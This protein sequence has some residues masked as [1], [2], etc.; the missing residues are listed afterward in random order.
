M[1]WKKIGVASRGLV[2]S[3]PSASFPEKLNPRTGPAGGISFFSVPLVHIISRENMQLHSYSDF[4]ARKNFQVDLV[5]VREFLFPVLSP[6]PLLPGW[7]R[8]DSMELQRRDVVRAVCSN[9][10][11]GLQRHDCSLK[12]QFENPQEH[13]DHSSEAC[14]QEKQQRQVAVARDGRMA[15]DGNWNQAQ[16]RGGCNRP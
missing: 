4:F 13:L 11:K 5:P 7:S 16:D 12:V 14:E 15:A 1:T 9:P 2:T 8:Y 6:L 3:A 10:S